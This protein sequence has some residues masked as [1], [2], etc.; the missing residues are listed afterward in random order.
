MEKHE[1]VWPWG[2]T[3]SDPEPGSRPWVFSPRNFLVA[4][5]GDDGEAERARTALKGVGFPDDDLRAYS[6]AQ[7]LEDRERYLAQQGPLRRV[8]G[9]VTS[10]AEAVKRFVRYARDGRAFLWCPRPRAGGRQPGHPGPVDPQGP[11]LPLLRG[12]RRGGRPHAV[13]RGVRGRLRPGRT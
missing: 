8:V 11:A 3:D 12:Q 10:D 9:Q 4:V 2:M 13:R 6:G 5:L 7:V 1:V